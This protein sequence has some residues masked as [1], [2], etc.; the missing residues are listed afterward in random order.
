M[1]VGVTNPR[2]GGGYVPGDC[3]KSKTLIQAI[4]AAGKTS[5]LKLCLDAGD[6]DSY[7]GSGETFFDV[8]GNNDDAWLGDD[9]D[10]SNNP[11]FNPEGAAGG[12]S[13]REYFTLGGAGYFQLKSGLPAWANTLHKDAVHLALFAGFYMPET[14]GS[15]NLC[16]T[17]SGT[18]ADVGFGFEVVDT[19]AVGT[20]WVM[21]AHGGSSVPFGAEAPALVIPGAWNFV[22]A[23][24]DEANTNGFMWTNGTALTDKVTHGSTVT[25]YSPDEPDFNGEGNYQSP[26]ASSATGPFVIGARSIGGASPSAPSVFSAAG[27]RLST[28]AA[29]T[30]AAIAAADFDAIYNEIKKRYPTP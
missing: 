11:T 30:G 12:R 27:S 29:W 21:G 24:I 1:S 25:N 9:G 18:S 15:M 19:G 28:F 6:A 7:P 14:P 16:S 26:S 17:T 8:S 4:T 13:C 20:V 5:G 22:G 23:Y 10:G 2:R 3:G